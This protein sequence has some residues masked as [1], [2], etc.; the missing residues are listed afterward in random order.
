MT[1]TWAFRTLGVVVAVT[2]IVATA[3]M[4]TATARGGE[5]AIQRWLTHRELRDA[6]RASTEATGLTNAHGM[7]CTERRG[8]LEVRVPCTFDG[9][10]L[11]RF[12]DGS[13]LLTLLHP[14]YHPLDPGARHIYIPPDPR[15]AE[16]QQAIGGLRS[17]VE[18]IEKSR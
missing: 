10:Q 9:V 13:L 15:V 17:R 12:P 18:N 16:L 2:G 3:V 1:W 14:E 5:A 8:E 7:Q 4:A 11:Q 6:V